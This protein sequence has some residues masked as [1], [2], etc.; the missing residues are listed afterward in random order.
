MPTTLTLTALQLEAIKASARQRVPS[1]V[2]RLDGILDVLVEPQ[3]WFP[4][5]HIVE[6]QSPVPFPAR[7]IHAALGADGEDRVLTGAAGNLAAVVASDPPAPFLST[8]EILQYALTCDF[9]TMDH[10]LGELTLR[11]FDDIPW[12]TDVPEW[13]RVLIESLEA[14]VGP[15]IRA[16][17]VYRNDDGTG[18]LVERWIL[19]ECALI[20]RD[21]GVGRDGAFS[22]VDTVFGRDLAVP[23]GRVWRV[24]GG[25]LIPVG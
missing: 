18:F 25:R 7:R 22:R 4:R 14:T 21:L 12:V 11:A 24:V 2:S 19:A 10:E 23:A 16:P 3:T 9:W 8:D 20:R 13:E 17:A 6:I 1:F 15:D 5:H